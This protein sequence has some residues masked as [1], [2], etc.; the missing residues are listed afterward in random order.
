MIDALAKVAR[1]RSKNM[2]GVTPIQN[3]FVR[4]ATEILRM[5][6]VTCHDIAV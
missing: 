4:P 1:L 6:S 2:N 5:F 3:P